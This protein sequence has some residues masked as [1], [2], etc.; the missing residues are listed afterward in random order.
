MT[1]SLLKL[2]IIPLILGLFLGSAHAA[3]PQPYLVKDIHPA[4]SSRADLKPLTD[5]IDSDGTLDLTTGFSGAL[6][7]TGWRM[8]YAPDGAP[9]TVGRTSRAAFP[10]ENL[11]RL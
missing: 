7:P 5:L 3:P 10:G 2:S 1:K 9:Q 4:G 11:A 6:D 8:E